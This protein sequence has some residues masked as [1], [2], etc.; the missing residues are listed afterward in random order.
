MKVTLSTPQQK[1]VVIH[2][3]TDGKEPGAASLL[4]TKPLEPTDTANLR[5]AAF[6][7]G[8]RVTLMSD[9]YF[10]RLGTLPPKPDIYLDQLESVTRRAA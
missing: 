9:G 8:Q 4:Y 2:Y 6:E 7:N 5:A 10:A 3:T 1:G